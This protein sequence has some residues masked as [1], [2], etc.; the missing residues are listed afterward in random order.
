MKHLRDPVAL[1]LL[2]HREPVGQFL[3]LPGTLLDP[4]LQR[5]V[6]VA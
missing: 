5:V 4:F 2:G 6:Q 1:G 3:H